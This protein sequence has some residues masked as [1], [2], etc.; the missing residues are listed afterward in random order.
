MWLTAQS[1]QPPPASL[2]LPLSGCRP[3]ISDAS[4]AQDSADA[5]QAT[6]D[7]KLSKLG[8]TMS[9]R[10]HGNQLITNLAAPVSASDAATRQ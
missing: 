1:M 6:A 10:S 3:A 8:D 5:A 4:D 2:L 9:A 7:L